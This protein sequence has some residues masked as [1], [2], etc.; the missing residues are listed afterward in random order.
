MLAAID[1]PLNENQKD[2]QIIC[3]MPKIWFDEA[4]QLHIPEDET[5]V[6]KLTQLVDD[7]DQVTRSVRAC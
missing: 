7:I 5:K 1:S 2:G 6:L 4:E 3:D